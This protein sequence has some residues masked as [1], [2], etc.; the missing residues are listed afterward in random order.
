MQTNGVEIIDLNALLESEGGNED[1]AQTPDDNQEAKNVQTQVE[2]DEGKGNQVVTGGGDGTAENEPVVGEKESG[3][4]KESEP[5]EEPTANS[6]G[7]YKEA[8]LKLME[9]GVLPKT[10]AFV[11]DEGNEIPLDEV[12]IDKDTFADIVKNYI[13][14]LKEKAKDE[15]LS[16]VSDITKK[17]IE[18][19]KAG[20]DVTKVLELYDKVM[21][22]L[23]KMDI[24]TEDGQIQ[25][26]YML[27]K[28]KG[29]SEDD[30]ANLIDAY[31]QKGILEEKAIESKDAISKAF[32]QL[33]EDE[34]KRA[35]QQ[36]QEFEK[37]IKQY[38]KSLREK[39]KERGLGSRV[40]DTI[41]SMAT[42]FDESGRTKIDEMFDTK[43]MNPEEAAELYHFLVDKEG[44]LK[45][46]LSE[47]V[48]KEKLNVMKKLRL[49]KKSNSK[50]NVDGFKKKDKHV[51]EFDISKLQ[52]NQ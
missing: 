7:F 27:N 34:K 44:Y 46:K 9:S 39:L 16:G 13:E 42:D 5:N 52:G 1:G 3:G 8:L 25:A 30:I 31:K 35:E 43:K 48:N 24:A 38:R 37:T 18:I 26:I 15:S 41:V 14:E 6:D 45:N 20:G 47:T 51:I 49:S 19:D 32:E 33:M 17:I 29:M 2:S 4:E 11:D 10:D 50:K 36:K 28:A 22:P 12:D 40:I 23:E 21:S